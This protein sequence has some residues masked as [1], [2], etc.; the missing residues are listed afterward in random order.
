MTSKAYYEAH[1][2][3]LA[4]KASAYHAEHRD[5]IRARQKRY[6]DDNA[7]AMRERSRDWRAANPER[8]A[9]VWH[10]YYLDNKARIW[11][12]WLLRKHGLTPEKLTELWLSQDEQCYLCGDNL[13]LSEAKIDHDH[14]CCPRHTSCASC[15]RG[16]ACHGCNL[17]LGHMGD[18]PARLRLM[19]DRLQVAL[20]LVEARMTAG[21]V[22][23]AL[24]GQPDQP[25]S[26]C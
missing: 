20:A 16:L 10:E 12:R 24:F 22:Q 2:D 23:D 17:M 14:R 19:A 1:K 6:Y 11:A 3:E 26:A 25:E 8:R 9:E 4:A 13:P 18:D 21:P 7:D 15:R 5:E